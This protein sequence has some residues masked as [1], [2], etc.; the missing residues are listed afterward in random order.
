MF[1]P[2]FKGVLV[3]RKPEVEVTP[4]GIIIPDTCKDKP[5]EGSVHSVG[6]EVKKIAPKDN[7]LCA[8]YAGVDLEL[9]DGNY[10]LLAEKDILGLIL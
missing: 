3:K 6:A 1:Q 7:V 5:M 4:G 2:L 8:K 9:E 10:L